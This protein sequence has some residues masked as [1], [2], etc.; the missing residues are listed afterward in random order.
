MSREAGVVHVRLDNPITIRKE[1]LK[2]AIDSTKM[3]YAFKEI[4]DLRARDIQLFGKL[5][6]INNEIKKAYS[7]LNNSG[8]P[9]LPKDL[10]IK[11]ETEVK[12]VNKIVS[13]D[14]DDL[15]TELREVEKRL[16]SL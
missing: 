12:E 6:K 8:F 7:G 13:N 4:V 11:N 3:L 16:Q 5:Q 2:T 15:M 10:H 9:D 14:V 1:I